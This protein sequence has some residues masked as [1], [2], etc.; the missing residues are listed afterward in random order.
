MRK[1]SIK[2]ILFIA[3]LTTCGMATADKGGFPAP[4]SPTIV[5]TALNAQEKALVITGRNFGA[6][7]PTVMLADQTLDVKHFSEHE[8]VANLPRDFAAATYGVI[9]TTTGQNRTHS[10]LFSATLPSSKK[11]E[12]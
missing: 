11:M 12:L 2:T 8:I 1:A 7:P 9:V 3:G 4:L 5:K 6:T 10:N